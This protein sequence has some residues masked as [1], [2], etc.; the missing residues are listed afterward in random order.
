[1][2]VGHF[3]WAVGEG[4]RVGFW[5]D[6]WV[7]EQLLKDLCPRLFQ[8]ASNKDGVVREMGQRETE[9]WRWN[10]E[11]RRGRIGREQGEEQVLGEMLESI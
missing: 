1:M 7:G 8:L 5:R 4:S 10:L 6:S 2:L 9:G 11:W 3:R